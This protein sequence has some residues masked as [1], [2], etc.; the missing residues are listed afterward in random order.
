MKDRTISDDIIYIGADDPDIDLFESQFEV[1]DGMCYNSY[2]IKDEKYV[3]M[4]TI[5][6]RATDKWLDNLKNALEGRNV[7]YLVVLHMEPDH[8]YNIDTL[9]KLYP[10]MKIIGNEKTFTSMNQFFGEIDNIENRK[11]VVKEGDEISF[12]KHTLNL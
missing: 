4:D 8:A 2:L 7:D 1:P 5:D 11:V 3:V 9:A 12:G 6:E 10:E